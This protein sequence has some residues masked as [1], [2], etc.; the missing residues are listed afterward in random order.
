MSNFPTQVNPPFRRLL[1]PMFKGPST[2]DDFV[3]HNLLCATCLILWTG[4][5]SENQSCTTSRKVVHDLEKSRP[6][7]YFG[8]I[9]SIPGVETTNHTAYFVAMTTRYDVVFY[10]TSGR[11]N[12]LLTFYTNISTCLNKDCILNL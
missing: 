11:Q 8:T 2:R 6:M 9:N 7:F 1:T 12:K 10:L 3:V 4:K 5:S